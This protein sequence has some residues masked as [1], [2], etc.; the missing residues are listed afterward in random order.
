MRDIY[1]RSKQYVVPA[2]THDL[3]SKIPSYC[4]FSVG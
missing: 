2:Q 3:L 1:Y 4:A